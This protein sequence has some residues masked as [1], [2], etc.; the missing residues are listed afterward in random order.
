MALPKMSVP[1][2][3]VTLPSTQEQI[4]MRPFLVREE[5]VLMIALE[6]ND[7]AQISRA[8][9]EIILSCYDLKNLDSLTVFDIEYLFLQLRA[10]SVGENMNIQIKCREEDCDELTPVSINVD[11]IAIINQEQ[12]RTILLDKD[13][14][15]GVEM[16]YPSLEL[17]SSL[18]ME[19]LESIEGVMDLIVKCIDSIFDNDNVYNADTESPEEL[20]SFV[21]SL[22]SEQ[23]KKIQLFLQDVPAVYYK[24][25]YDCKCGRKQEVELRG[26]NSF[27]T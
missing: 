26:L 22:S 3:M 9:K 15:V 25:D 27:F 5:K 6:S 14:G 8:V 21:E 11:D 10:K 23:F 13:T 20:S 7:A 19:K 16:R 1:K 17:V 24:A 18:D 2:Y 4:S 12:E